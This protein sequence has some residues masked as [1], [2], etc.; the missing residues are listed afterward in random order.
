MVS[1]FAAALCKPFKGYNIYVKQKKCKEKT[2]KYNNKIIDREW[3]R[4]MTKTIISTYEPPHAG[5]R[6]TVQ[7]QVCCLVNGRFT[8]PQKYALV[9]FKLVDYNSLCHS[10]YKALHVVVHSQ[11]S[12][13][14]TWKLIIKY[15]HHKAITISNLSY[16]V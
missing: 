16:G 6:K 5:G 4:K 9:A 2:D 12:M 14:K 3:K 1:N 8:A 13:T 11:L 15:P 10:V 7:K